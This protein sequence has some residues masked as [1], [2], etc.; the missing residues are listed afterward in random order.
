MELFDQNFIDEWYPTTKERDEY[1]EKGR[2]SLK[3][4]HAQILA[5]TPTVYAIEKGFTLKLGEVVVK[6]RIDRIDRLA[7]GLEIIDYKTGSPKSKLEWDD[8]RQ[9]VLYAM[10][11]EQS[12]PDAPPVKKLTYYYLNSNEVVSFEPTDK[13][14]DKLR[15]LILETCE[16]IGQ[17]DFA[18]EPDVMKCK[19]CDFRDICPA[20][21]F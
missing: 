21:K 5:E 1:R 6:G 8:R 12:F 9:L 10:A 11:V 20:A 3:K 14:K 19:Y 7:E 16:K 13:D 17:S 4:L 15:D 2:E 18:P